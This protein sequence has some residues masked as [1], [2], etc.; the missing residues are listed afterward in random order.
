MVRS[1]LFGVIIIY[2][3]I[4]NLSMHKLETCHSPIRQVTI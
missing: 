1:K 2:C 4:V 3:F